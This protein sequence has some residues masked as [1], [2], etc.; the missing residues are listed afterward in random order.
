MKSSLKEKGLTEKQIQIAELVSS[1]LSNQQVAQSLGVTEKA[2]K[3]HLTNVYKTLK[4]KTRT[5]LV[6]FWMETKKDKENIR[7]GFID[8]T[9]FNH[10]LGPGNDPMPTKIYG[11]E[12]LLRAAESCAEEC[13]CY[14]VEVKVLRFIPGKPNVP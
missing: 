12:E 3:W 11:S 9:D 13:G 4:I 2:V 1:G 8:A 14:E 7:T 10:H 6:L 5:Q